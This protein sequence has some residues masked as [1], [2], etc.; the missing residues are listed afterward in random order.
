MS[1]PIT[2]FVYR[3]TEGDMNCD[4]RGERAT[5]KQNKSETDGNVKILAAETLDDLSHKVEKIV[6]WFLFFS[7][8]V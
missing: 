8:I 4:S 7:F 2:T 6:Q 1:L 3:V 5:Q